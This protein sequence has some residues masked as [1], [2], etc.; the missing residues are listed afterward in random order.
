MASPLLRTK[1]E[2]MNELCEFWEG[3]FTGQKVTIKSS[4]KVH[5]KKFEREA[6]CLRN[7]GQHPKIVS[8]VDLFVDKH[9]AML[10]Y[11]Y[12]DE[13]LSLSYMLTRS[14]LLDIEMDVLMSVANAL[15]HIH[16]HKYIH[17]DVKSSNIFID[18]KGHIRLGKN[19]KQK[20][21]LNSRH[22]IISCYN[23]RLS[24]F[25]LV[26]SLSSTEPPSGETGTYRW[27]VTN[28]RIIIMT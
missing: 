3:E 27:Y 26:Y 5:L 18:S 9:H 20:Y 13:E 17:R 6:E 25:D 22:A 10:I 16:M 1:K 21:A 14:N 19:T 28:H 23:S 8:F 12:M 4:S 11:E 2:G 7:L 24:G 15:E